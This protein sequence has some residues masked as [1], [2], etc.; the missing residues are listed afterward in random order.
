MFFAQSVP[1]SLH[2]SQMKLPG[3]SF[4]P[5]A[6]IPVVV[7]KVTVI[8]FVLSNACPHVLR[9]HLL[10]RFYLHLYTISIAIFMFSVSFLLSICLLFSVFCDVLL[11]TLT[12][13]RSPPSLPSNSQTPKRSNTQGTTW[14]QRAACVV[15]AV[16]LLTRQ[17]CKPW[18]Y[19]QMKIVG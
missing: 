2:T 8:N 4:S 12:F 19:L 13:F 5:S 16:E 15:D 7:Q 3:L 10:V 1:W 11:L 9:F 14:P 17:R 18:T 6:C